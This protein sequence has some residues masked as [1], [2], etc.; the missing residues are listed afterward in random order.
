MIPVVFLLSGSIMVRGRKRITE[1]HGQTSEDVIRRA[2]Q[3]VQGGQSIRD[4][5]KALNISKATLQCYVTNAKTKGLDDI[6]IKN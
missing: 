5:A 4:T 1:T 3:A 6:K 2:V